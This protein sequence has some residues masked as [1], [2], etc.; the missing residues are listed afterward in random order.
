MLLK[1]HIKK[2]N[3]LVLIFQCKQRLIRMEI[4]YILQQMRIILLKT[5]LYIIK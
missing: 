4:K 3:L 5:I 1:K 2:E